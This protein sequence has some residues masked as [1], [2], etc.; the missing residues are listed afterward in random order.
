MNSKSFPP[1]LGS[2]LAFPVEPQRESG[3]GRGIPFV[4]GEDNIRQSI[5]I[6]LA[7]RKG[8]RP[9]NPDFGSTLHHLAFEPADE[10]TAGRAEEAVREALI[11]WEPR[12]DVVS[13]AGIVAEDEPNVLELEI[14]YRVRSTN[15]IYNLVYPFYLGRG[16]E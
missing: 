2:G 10:A 3:D 6:V 11:L 12:I 7:T 14:Q 15:S 5:L 8:E 4:T 13:V 1:F 16:A 9:A